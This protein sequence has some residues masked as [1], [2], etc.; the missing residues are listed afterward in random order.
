MIGTEVIAQ[1]AEWM[2]E[3]RDPEVLLAHDRLPAWGKPQCLYGSLDGIKVPVD[4]QWQELKVGCWYQAESSPT[5]HPPDE[6]EGEQRRA[7]HVT[8][9]T[10]FLEAQVFAELLWGTGCQRLADQPEEVVFVADGATW[11]C[12]S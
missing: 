10:D 4:G 11:I 9:Y 2:A 6:Q 7:T 5:D 12:L 1:Q 8:Y 3:S